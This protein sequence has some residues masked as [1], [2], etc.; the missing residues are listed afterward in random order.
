MLADVVA[1]MHLTSDAATDLGGVLDLAN[2]AS[3]LE[4][5]VELALV[6]VVLH[7]ILHHVLTLAV[8]LVA[9]NHNA[10]VHLFVVSDLS[11][12]KQN[13]VW[14]V[15][16]VFVKDRFWVE[17]WFLIIFVVLVA[18]EAETNGYLLFL[19][20]VDIF[21]PEIDNNHLSTLHEVS[22]SCLNE[23]LVLVDF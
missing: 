8:A 3:T 13:I 10:I 20:L 4:V 7:T 16:F 15:H 5:L 22:V 6:L 23:A 14:I 19:W 21:L 11:D 18:S 9:L 2:G 1:V 12:V 17:I